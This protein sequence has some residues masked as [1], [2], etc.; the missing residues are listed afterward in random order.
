MRLVAKLLGLTFFGGIA[1]LAAPRAGAM[2]LTQSQATSNV[3]LCVDVKH[4]STKLDAVVWAFPC[5]GTIAEQWHFVGPQLQG[6]MPNRCLATKGGGTAD[7]THVVLSACTTGVP[8]QRWGY[9]DTLIFLLNTNP[10]ECLDS[11]LG[12]EQSLVIHACSAGAL[13]Q[14]WTLH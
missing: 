1:V 5:N 6:L 12:V 7:G 8:G 14:Q 9:Q 2:L 13:T 11:E 3:T 10:S 4:S